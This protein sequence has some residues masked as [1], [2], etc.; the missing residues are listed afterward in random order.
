MCS[1]DLI[2]LAEEF[3]SHEFKMNYTIENVYHNFDHTYD[4][5]LT[6]NEIALALNINSY[7]LEDLIVASWFHDIGYL[8]TCVGHEKISSEKAKIFLIRNH[9]PKEKIN[10]VVDCILATRIPQCPTSKIGEILCDADLHHLGSPEFFHRSDLLREEI[11]L[12]DN[13]IFTDAEWIQKSINFLYA[14]HFFTDFAI[15]KYG[16]QKEENLKVLEK[17]LEDIL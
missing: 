13:C 7:N 4:V 15:E 16:I 11:Q 8:Q 3:I 12:K 1:N 9:V 14:H 2:I 10:N 6:A 5:A 17:L